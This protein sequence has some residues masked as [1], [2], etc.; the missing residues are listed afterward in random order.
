MSEAQIDQ[1]WTTDDD[2][3]TLTVSIAPGSIS[4]NGGSA[5]ATVTRNTD[6]TAEEGSN[7]LVIA[8]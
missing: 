4:E 5:T 1:L 2:T 6:T 3:A 8:Q 7:D